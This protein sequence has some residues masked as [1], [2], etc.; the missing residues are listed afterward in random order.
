MG[1]PREDGFDITAA[2]E[3]MAILC[4]SQRLRRP[5]GAPRPHPARLHARGPAGLRRATSTPRA[6]WP[7][8]CATRCCRT[9]CRPTEG[10]PALVHG[11]P[12][13]N[14]A[15]GCNSLVATRLALRRAEVVFT[16]AGF[17]FDLGAEKFLDI[18][19]R[20]AGIW[21][22]A[23]VLVATLRA[24]KFHGGVPA[25]DAAKE[26]AKALG[27][28][29]GEPREAPR[30]RARSSASSPWWRSTCAPRTPQASCSTS[31][32][33]CKQD[34]RRGRPRRRL[35]ARAERAPRPWPRRSWRARRGRHPEAALHLRARRSAGREDPQDRPRHLRR[36][37]GGL[38]R[39]GQVPA[40][41]RGPARASARCRSAW[42]RRTSRCPTTSGAL[43][44]PRD[45]EMTVR[46]VR[47]A[48]G[49]GFLVPL[50]GEILTMP[51]LPKRPARR[52]T[53]TSRPTGPSSASSS[54]PGQGSATLLLLLASCGGDSA[55]S[56]ARRPAARSRVVERVLEGHTQRVTAVAFAPDSRM[57]ATGS[58]DATV[59]LWNV[60]DGVLQRSSRGSR[61]PSFRSP[62]LATARCSPRAART[63]RS[64]SGGPAMASWCA[65]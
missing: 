42:P 55:P 16:E 15:H 39:R 12:F 61:A 40:R 20:A 52:W 48:A 5:Q 47:I 50:T 59:K 45:F 35:R 33:A 13:G 6:P 3:V 37:R 53:S 26:N 44:R 56:P 41:P 28:G 43:G 22:H 38:H 11:G 51:G 32:T 62:S 8:C 63:R 46:E 34:G 10:A 65:A 9:S 19:C 2:S 24:L 4:L 27:A 7:R 58:V 64:G 60:A 25:A 23:V 1:V 18:K 49:A 17:G 21:P 30:E 14:I 29:H 54:R 31:S 57:L 36:G